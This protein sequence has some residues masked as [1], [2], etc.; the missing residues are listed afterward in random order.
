MLPTCGKLISLR[1][2]VEK[3]A[4]LLIDGRH[5]GSVSTSMVEITSKCLYRHR[6]VC[7]INKE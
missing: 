5:L 6:S 7:Y 3:N 1:K 4:I 2:K